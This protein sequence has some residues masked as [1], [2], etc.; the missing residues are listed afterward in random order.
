MPEIRL[1]AG[2]VHYRDDGKGA[3]VVLLHANPGDSRDFD[4]V[5]G[6]LAARHRVIALDWPG[7]GRSAVPPDPTA[8]GLAFFHRVLLEFVSAL[9][10]PPAIFIGNSM[11]GWAAVRLACE[12]PGVVRGL[13]LVSPGGFTSPNLLASAFCGLQASRFSLPPAWFAKLYLRRKTPWVRDML[14]RA[15]DEQSV[16]ERR[17]LN[18]AVWGSFARGEGDLRTSA[19]GV[20]APTL[21]VLGSRDPV[22]SALRDGRVAAQT[23]ERSRLVCLPCG[24]AAF[25]EMPERFLAET[26][27]F[28]AGL[29]A[30]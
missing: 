4:C 26:G 18:R 23:I 13:V 11:G 16:A 2:T 5:S 6:E 19:R 20:K 1:S 8:V 17:A 7:Y 25:A 14:K 9:A 10:L 3:V 22:I 24:H 28:I 21:L 27:G 30:S 12:R 15:G 29:E